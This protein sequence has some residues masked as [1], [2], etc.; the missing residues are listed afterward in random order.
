MLV[1][2]IVYWKV[3]LKEEDRVGI[4]Q[5]WV[6]LLIFCIHDRCNYSVNHRVT[7]TS[8][9]GSTANNGTWYK[10]EI[11]FVFQERLPPVSITW[12]KWRVLSKNTEVWRK[13]SCACFHPLTLLCVTGNILGVT[14]C[15]FCPWEVEREDERETPFSLLPIVLPPLLAVSSSMNLALSCSSWLF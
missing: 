7:R 6:P 9:Q 12:E 11:L 5:L 1:F 13:P 10:I 2:Y 8:T 14:F 15:R 3:F 4:Y